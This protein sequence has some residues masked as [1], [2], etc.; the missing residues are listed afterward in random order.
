MF[1]IYKIFEI[2]ANIIL[3]NVQYSQNIQDQNT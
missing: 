2:K 3:A 1:H